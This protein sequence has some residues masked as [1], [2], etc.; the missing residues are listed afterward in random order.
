MNRARRK[1]PPVYAAPSLA[2]SRVA[3]VRVVHVHRIAGI[4]GSERHLLALLPA[5]AAF[6]VEPL[7]LGLDVPSAAPDPFYDRL[8]EDGVEFVRVPAPRDL[9]PGLARRVVRLVRG[10]KPD[11]VHTHLVHGDLYGAAGAAA[12]RARLVSTKH[13]DDPF[14]A[15]PFRYVDRALTLRTSAV[16]CITHALARFVVD[17]VGLPA[18]K[19]VVVP[20]GL[21]ASPEP[22]GPNT[23]LALPP[24]A[25][26]LLA[27]AR[28]APQ[29]GLD[30]AIRALADLR[31]RGHRAVLV[32]LGEGRERSRLTALAAELGIADAVFL[33]GRE[34]D[35]G[36]WLRRADVLVHPAR[37]EGFGLA[38]LEAML[39]GRPVVATRVS[40]IPEL[41]V[42]GETGV[43][44]AP[45]DASAFAD[46]V[47]SLLVDPARAAAM[48][49][50][51]RARALA[52]FSVE[53]MARRTNEVY[54]R[55]AA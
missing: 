3:A 32:V 21:D 8:G 55:V 28:L 33:P 16:V 42:D 54:V 15:G 41:V 24:D 44:V 6:G 13:N 47:A 52:E 31:A 23:D 19:V 4:G 30:V 14:R 37:W 11:V 36:A 7:M 34:G 9:D 20:Y 22:W 53:E 18:R 17:C 46:A 48:G 35:V 2:G 39:V 43:L 45:D 10:A 38:I 1:A 25:P 29:K 51:G 49:E 40:A 50:R 5:L 27:I 12:S 26:L